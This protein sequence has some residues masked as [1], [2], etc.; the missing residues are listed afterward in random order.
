MCATSDNTTHKNTHTSALTTPLPARNAHAA[1]PAQLVHA[2]NNNIAQA[3]RGKGH[4][5]G[6]DSPQHGLDVADVAARVVA[7]RAAHR[8]QIL[9][10]HG[11]TQTRSHRHSH[12]HRPAGPQPSPGSGNAPSQR[13]RQQLTGPSAH[14][15]ACTHSGTAGRGVNTPAPGAGRRR[16]AARQRVCTQAC[17]QSGEA[18]QARA[19]THTELPAKCP[20]RRSEG[21]GQA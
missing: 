5:A 20:L 1:D 21:G 7:E 3:S 14:V 19:H 18:A 16:I 11:E 13:G 6:G 10:S 2:G 15:Q 17:T 4:R 9:L 8:Q 12:T